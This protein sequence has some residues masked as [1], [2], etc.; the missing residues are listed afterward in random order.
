MTLLPESSMDYKTVMTRVTTLNLRSIGVDHVVV[1][2]SATGGRII[3]VPGADSG[4]TADTLAEKLREIIGD[5]AE[6]KRPYKSAQI[7]VSGFNEAVTPE[8]LRDAAADV[9]K[10]PPGQIRVGA[11][12]MAPDQTGSTILTCPVVA[13]NILIEAGSLSIG[14]SAAKVRGL[15]ALPMRCYR[16]M[17]IG[18][19]K[20][21]CPS[22]V[23]RSTLCNR[24]G[25]TDHVTP[26]CG[27]KVPCCAVCSAAKIPAKHVMG[28]K[29]CNPPRTR[30][31]PAST[32]REV[33]EDNTME[34]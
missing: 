5:V 16:C 6:V 23:D 25:G 4:A 26:D 10:C 18:H 14:W 11:I 15:D 30:G 7:R 28:G 24:C 33:S 13:A 29:A 20:A 34:Q 12:R 8:A 3:E 31:K 17:G 32:A 1:R 21:L 2:R 22:P 9:G 27:V 19:T